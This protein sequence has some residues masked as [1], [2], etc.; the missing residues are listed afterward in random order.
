MELNID[1]PRLPCGW[2]KGRAPHWRSTVVIFEKTTVS[3][4]QIKRGRQ[5]SWLLLSVLNEAVFPELKAL[6]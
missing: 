4:I 5:V 3:L 6:L 1:F 2:R